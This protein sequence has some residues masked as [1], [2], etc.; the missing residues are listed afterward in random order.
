VSIGAIFQQAVTG[1][2]LVRAKVVVDST[3]ALQV[4]VA[5]LICAG[6][7]VVRYLFK[8][9]KASSQRGVNSLCSLVVDLPCSPLRGSWERAGLVR[10]VEKKTLLEIA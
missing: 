1:E 3:N 2:E 5:T 7:A 4:A 8:V 6:H 10:V 9:S